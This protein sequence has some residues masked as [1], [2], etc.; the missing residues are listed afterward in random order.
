[1]AK[2]SHEYSRNSPDKYFKI[3]NN[4]L[5]KLQSKPLMRTNNKFHEKP[6]FVPTFL[7][8]FPRS[9][10]TLLDTILRSNSKINVVEEQDML[11]AAKSFLRQNGHNDFVTELIPSQLNVQAQK[12]T[13]ENLTNTSIRLQ[14][15][16]YL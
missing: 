11:W 1:M 13:K 16:K 8:G 6:I 12:S 9:G 2:Q 5:R 7:V 3:L 14:Q 15:T 4:E 10:T